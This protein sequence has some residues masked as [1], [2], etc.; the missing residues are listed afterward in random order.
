M[1]HSNINSN[2]FFFYKPNFPF[3]TFFFKIKCLIANI[4][5]YFFKHFSLTIHQTKLMIRYHSFSGWW[6]FPISYEVINSIE[7]VLS[8]TSRL[9]IQDRFIHPIR[10]LMVLWTYQELKM[11]TFPWNMLSALDKLYLILPYPTYF[12]YLTTGLIWK[13]ITTFYPVN[14]F[15]IEKD[16]NNMYDNDI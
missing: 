13:Y 4:F 9:I 10:G 11:Q 2:S 1:K 16:Q 3:Q 12:I 8:L 15:T 7:N 6:Y 5:H 14:L